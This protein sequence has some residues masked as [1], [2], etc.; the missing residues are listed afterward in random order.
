M[1]EPR[2]TYVYVHLG[3]VFVPAGRLT[4]HADRANEHA[5][6]RYGT[7]YLQRPDRLELDP[8]S[9]RFPSGSDRVLRTE[10]SFPLFGAIRDAAP[11]GWGRHVL[12]RAARGVP[13]SELDYLTAA[14][15]DR[16]GAL[17]FGPDLGG[18]RRVTPW[19]EPA[20]LFGEA[21]DLSELLQAA[22]QVASAEE[23]DPR[24][25]TFIQRGS[26]LGGAR[27]KA[28]T[29][30]HGRPF[31]AKFA[32]Q[33]D[34]VSLC[35]LEHA[36]MLLARACGITTPAVDRITV[37]GRDV[38][39]IERFDREARSAAVVNRDAAGAR[40]HFISALT[41]LGAHESESS[42]YAYSDIAA[43]LR[44][45]GSRFAADAE[46][47][48]RRMVFNILCNNTDDHLRN[49]GFLHDGHGYRLSP[50][51]DLVPFPQIGRVRLLALGV[52]AQG[53]VASVD[54]ALS[55]CASFG[56][57]REAALQLITQMQAV[58]RGWEAHYRAC[59]VPDLD[60][61]RVAT[62]FAAL[63]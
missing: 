57:S 13:L 51:Y 11:D 26:S 3:G 49:H 53:R 10:A 34:R 60:L 9:L 1:A 7:R 21:L 18:P 35:R 46:E 14:G 4:V 2:S 36:T 5:L 23:L 44:Q 33:D 59:D 48:Y 27:P 54:N 55:R 16:I 56:L 15:E 61:Q 37:L 8:V 24:F 25:A 17:A 41:L 28:T 31:I 45:H 39:L 50:A 47:L 38:Y 52:G 58:C 19:T 30:W 22:D 42:R 20:E 12:D 29:N 63:E 32:R 62:C 6:F 40:R 43:A